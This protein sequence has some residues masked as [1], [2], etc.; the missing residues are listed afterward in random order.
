MKQVR[1]KPFNPESLRTEIKGAKNARCFASK[2]VQYLILLVKVDGWCHYFLPKSPHEII[3]QIIT[4]KL[5]KYS[6]RSEVIHSEESEKL[7]NYSVLGR[8]FD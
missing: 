7:K 5:V 4:F 6:S 3:T 1:T 2:A 8:F